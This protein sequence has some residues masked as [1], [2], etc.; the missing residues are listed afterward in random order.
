MELL[1][2]NFY[3]CN[4]KALMHEIF[5]GSRENKTWSLLGSEHATLLDSE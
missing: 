1:F 3:L 2:R 4:I 5:G